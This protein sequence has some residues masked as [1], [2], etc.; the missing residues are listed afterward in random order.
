MEYNEAMLLAQ[1]VDS[2]D[3]SYRNLEK[4]HEKKDKEK[5]DYYK[6]VVLDFQ[7]KIAFILK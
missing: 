2:L 3:I 1:L 5:F 6:R 7:K 4:A